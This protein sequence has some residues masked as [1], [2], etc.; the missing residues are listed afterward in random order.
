MRAGQIKAIPTGFSVSTFLFGWIPSAIRGH[1]S[2]ALRCAFFD[3]LAFILIILASFFSADVGAIAIVFAPFA[4]RFPLALQ[5]NEALD[6]WLKEDGW[7][8]FDSVDY[9]TK[10]VQDYED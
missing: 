1:W 4:F 10:Y 7:D 5:R 8:D 2:F 3:L 6:Q 9:L